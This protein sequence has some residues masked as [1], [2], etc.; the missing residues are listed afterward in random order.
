M[1]DQ[2]SH[3]FLVLGAMMCWSVVVSLDIAGCCPV[4]CLGV[5]LLPGL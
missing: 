4:L 1:E 5:V 2:H 3:H